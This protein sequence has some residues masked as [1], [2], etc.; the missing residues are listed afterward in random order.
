[1]N[2]VE[3]LNPE[4]FPVP[5]AV[6]VRS[7]STASKFPATNAE[8]SSNR[9]TPPVHPRALVH[10]APTALAKRNVSSSDQP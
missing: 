6:Q 3:W 1:M 4:A 10:E 9:K 5:A 2:E 7:L 8:A